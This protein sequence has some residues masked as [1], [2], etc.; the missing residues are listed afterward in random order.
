MRSLAS[1]PWR[2]PITEHPLGDLPGKRGLT[3]LDFPGAR[4]HERPQASL[5]VHRAFLLERA[6]GMLDR[7]RVHLD[8]RRELAHGRKRVFRFEH[9]YCNRPLHLVCNLPEHRARILRVD[10]HVHVPTLAH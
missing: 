2:Y 5:D 1:S 4:R 10:I 7:I 3:A 6:V 9:S 8:L